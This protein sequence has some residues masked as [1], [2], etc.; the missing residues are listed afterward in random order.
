MHQSNLSSLESVHWNTSL[1]AMHQSNLSSL[2][3]VHWNTYL[4]AMHQSNLSIALNLSTYY[5]FG[6]D[7]TAM[8]EKKNYVL[9]KDQQS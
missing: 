9:R 6:E 3:S 5:R 7:C 4:L 2:E 1:P 8:G